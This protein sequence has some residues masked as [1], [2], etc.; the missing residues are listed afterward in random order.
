MVLLEINSIG[1]D[2][3]GNPGIVATDVLI[4]FKTALWFWMNNVHS[5]LDQG[6]GAT[7]RAINGAVECNGGNTPAVNAR[8]GYYKDYCS[9]LGVSPG[10]NLTS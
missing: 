10:D 5:V 4:S 2:G 3:L 7:I 9:H 1:F 6:F 8:V